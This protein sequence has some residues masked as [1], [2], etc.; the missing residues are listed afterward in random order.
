M[1]TMKRMV[2]M[3]KKKKVE[4]KTERKNERKKEEQ[5]IE[6]EQKKNTK[7]KKIEK[8]VGSNSNEKLDSF[9]VLTLLKSKKVFYEEN[10]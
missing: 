8:T 9:N 1:M 10:D 3:M 5:K 2:M 6:G 7:T 4:S